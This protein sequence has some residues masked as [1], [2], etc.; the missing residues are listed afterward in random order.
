[1]IRIKNCLLRNKKYIFVDFFDTVMF[2]KIHSNQMMQLWDES[3]SAK[4]NIKEGILTQVRINIIRKY[5]SNECAIAYETLCND[6]YYGLKKQIPEVSKK[7]FYRF[8]KEIEMYI[9][10]GVQYVNRE[11]IKFLKKWKKRG[12]KIILVSDYYLSADVYEV[13]MN[14]NNIA[15]IFDKIYCSSDIGKTKC[16]EGDLYPTIL[17][18]LGVNAE[19]VFMI[20]DS[21]VSDVTNAKKYGIEAYR[22]FPFVH[23][24]RT[25]INKMVDRNCKEIAYKNILKEAKKNCIFGVYSYP[26]VY[27]TKELHERLALEKQNANFLSR[28]GYFLKKLFDAY[29]ELVIPQP[30]RIDSFYVFNSRKVNEKAKN[31][32]MDRKLLFDYLKPY[33]KEDKFCFIDE[34]WY[35]HGQIIFTEILGIK[36][37]GFYLGL[38]D[39]YS[40]ADCE[41]EGILFGMSEGRKTSEYYGVFRTN[42]TLYEQI[43]TAPSG[44]VQRYYR[45]ELGSIDVELKQN[46]KENNIYQMYTKRIQEQLLSYVS[47]LFVYQYDTS[48]FELSKKLLKELLFAGYEKRS[49]LLQYNES[50]FDN[51]VDSSKKKFGKK[52]DIHI[53]F[54]DLIKNPE[55]YMRYFCKLREKFNTRFSY[56]L[57]CPLGMCIYLYTYGSLIIKH[58]NRKKNEQNKN[59][60]D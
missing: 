1:M 21:L 58:M 5:M 26:L 32:E 51:V 15:E 39:N 22:Y 24:I 7:E 30:Q 54:L 6:I 4:L 23:K 13:F 53:E 34:G 45:N 57:Y 19:E 16:G 36:T 47:T 46:P 59:R 3:F 10:Y 31:N 33:F 8:S 37:K 49:I 35:G 38:M 42:C 40:I 52:S 9:E 60:N 17:K 29:E 56:I 11:M 27:F 18:D 48:R 55:N 41:R 2:R 43:L 28:G 12:K 20:G 25:N 44:S 50:Y 14:K